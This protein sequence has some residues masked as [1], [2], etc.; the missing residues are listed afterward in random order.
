MKV[1]LISSSE[2]AYVLRVRLGPVRDWDDVLTDMRRGKATYADQVLLPFAQVHDG[3]ANRPYY[4]GVDVQDFLERV[5]AIEP[6]PS[7]VKE[8][9]SITVD[10]DPVDGLP[11]LFWKT[12]RL[13]AAA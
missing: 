8:L 2:V 6:P 11:P 5:V 7:N 4:R 13:K 12:R 9:R 10:V 1:K 3:R